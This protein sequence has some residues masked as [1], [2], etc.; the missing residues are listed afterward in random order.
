VCIWGLIDREVPPRAAFNS[1][2]LWKGDWEYLARYLIKFDSG[3][4]DQLIECV[5]N[6][7]PAFAIAY[8]WLAGHLP[9][10]LASISPVVLKMEIGGHEDI[11][12]EYLRG[13]I[14]AKS[15]IEEV[16]EPIISTIVLCSKFLTSVLEDVSDGMITASDI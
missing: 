3:H 5:Q 10:V 1:V 14:T 7:V 8:K 13:T 16:L 2:Y 6:S 11:V 15:D 9:D 4:T 12:T